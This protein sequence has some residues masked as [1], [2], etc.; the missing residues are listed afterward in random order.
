MFRYH[1]HVCYGSMPGRSISLR[2]IISPF[3]YW[4]KAE[5]IFIFLFILQLLGKSKDHFIFL[6]T[7]QLLGKSKDHLPFVVMNHLIFYFICCGTDWLQYN[8]VGIM[9]CYSHRYPQHDHVAC[10]ILYFLFLCLVWIGYD[11]I[12]L[13]PWGGIAIRKLLLSF[14]IIIH[15]CGIN[16]LQNDSISIERCYN[17]RYP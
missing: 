4:G 15:F 3:N 17:H 13:A 1:I 6:F 11:M 12:V 2:L 9:R 14:A 10:I 7:L 16:W 5:I 8:N